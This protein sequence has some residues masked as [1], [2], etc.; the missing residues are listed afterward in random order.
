MPKRG[1]GEDIQKER[2]RERVSTI[3]RMAEYEIHSQRDIRMY[4]NNIYCKY[5]REYNVF[6]NYLI[7][8]EVSLITLVLYT[9]KY[10]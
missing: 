3:L 8:K 4:V 7:N 9:L 5:Q 2:E 1:G 6:L 10:I